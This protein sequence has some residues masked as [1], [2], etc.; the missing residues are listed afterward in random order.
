MA[1]E[2]QNNA[3]TAG[4]PPRYMR[5]PDIPDSKLYADISKLG[6]QAQEWE[7]FKELASRVSS[8]QQVTNLHRLIMTRNLR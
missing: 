3:G 2:Q 6:P 5:M 1:D 4:Q 8:K 7:K